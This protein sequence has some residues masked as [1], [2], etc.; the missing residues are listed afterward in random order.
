MNPYDF[1]RIDWNRPPERRKPVWH[2][3]LT[4]TEGQHLYSGN[5]ELDIYVETP[6]FIADPRTAPTDPRRPAQSIKNKPGDYII[7][8]S[9]LKG[10]L[11][12]VVEALGNGCLTLF[13]GRYEG[14]VNYRYKVPEAFQK[15]GDNTKLCIACRI[16]GML[17]E[18]TSGVFLGKVNIG[19]AVAVENSVVVCD[20]MYTA[21]L[22][23]PKP[24]HADFYQ[25]ETRTHIAGRKFY[26]H[27]S[28]EQPL[29][30]TD[31]LVLMGGRPANR[32]IQPLDNGTKF[33]VRIDFTNLEEDEFGALLLAVTLEENM[34]HKIGYGKP[35][36]LG[37]ISL[38][39]TSLTLVDYATRYTQTGEGRG[40]KTLSG[41]DLWQQ[42]IYEQLDAFSATHLVHSAMEDLQR[43]WAWPADDSV[44]YY[45]P[46]KRDW[47][48]TEDSKGKRIADTRSVPRQ[49]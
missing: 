36:G 13:D 38:S 28:L 18:R 46:S 1:V 49:Q 10:M 45:Y 33:H 12:T 9:S 6:L 7:P 37:S 39:P 24:R 21:V 30:T 8:G 40:K 31:R 32:Y 11:R 25:D 48:D 29:L 20:P 15:C 19:D 43:I 35:L 4:G 34:R 22:V 47:F 41:N 16:F 23:T 3:R 42:V 17:K 2:H 44:D 14:D 26:F 5:I 27:H